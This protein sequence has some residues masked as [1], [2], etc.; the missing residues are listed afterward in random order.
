MENDPEKKHAGI[1]LKNV[2]M[3]LQLIYPKKHQLVYGL[4][5]DEFVA[6]LNV[7]L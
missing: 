5:G 3:R 1:G 6:R 2:E 4:K 7:Q